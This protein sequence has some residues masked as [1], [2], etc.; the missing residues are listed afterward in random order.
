MFAP[1]NY[2]LKL[3]TLIE[4]FILGFTKRKSFE[5]VEFDLFLLGDNPFV[6]F[7]SV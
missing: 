2:A 5:S 7:A 1:L 6:P 4:G 3:D